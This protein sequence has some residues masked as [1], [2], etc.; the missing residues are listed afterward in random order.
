[1]PS[2][3]GEFSRGALELHYF[4]GCSPHFFII[5]KQA[6]ETK[7]C[8]NRRVV[9]RAQSLGNGKWEIYEIPNSWEF[10]GIR[11]SRR[12]SWKVKKIG[13]PRKKIRF[14]SGKVIFSR[15]KLTFPRET[16]LRPINKL[17]AQS[18][19]HFIAWGRSV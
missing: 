12:K 10:P 18:C 1:M 14:F 3:L 15:R 17:F 11:N 6:H 8:Q 16:L 9:S 13:D 2:L 4:L 7:L 19:S 5:Q